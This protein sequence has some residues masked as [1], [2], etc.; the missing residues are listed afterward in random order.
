MAG[1]GEAADVGIAGGVCGCV[2]GQVSIDV[3]AR[4]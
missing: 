2:F 1:S 3:R 4:A